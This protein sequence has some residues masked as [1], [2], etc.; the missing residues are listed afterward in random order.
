MS[1]SFSRA[2]ICNVIS[3]IYFNNSF[4]AFI[5]PQQN[6]ENTNNNIILYPP[7][8][9]AGT[10]PPGCRCVLE[11]DREG[12]EGARE[13]SSG[14]G[15]RPPPHLL[16]AGPRQPQQETYSGC[17]QFSFLAAFSLYFPMLFFFFPIFS[18]LFLPIRFLF[19][20]LFASIL[21]ML[22]KRP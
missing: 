1:N 3:F 6:I 20:S 2:N 5:K 8:G 14:H 21:E 15:L 11:G 19:S 18:P 4:S 16:Q 17:I 9:L 10:D 7:P 22:F 13:G 12:F